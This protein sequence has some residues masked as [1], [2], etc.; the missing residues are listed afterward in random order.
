MKTR[1]YS[2][3]SDLDIPNAELVKKCRNL[4]F[5]VRNHMSTLDEGEVQVLKREIERERQEPVK[6]TVLKSGVLLRKGVHKPK[7]KPVEPEPPPSPP[8]AEPARAAAPE[9]APP[10]PASPAAPPG[11]A[12]APSPEAQEPAPAASEAAPPAPAPPAAPPGEAA[13]PSPEAQEPAPA[14][15][16]PAV[17]PAT[18][19]PEAEPPAEPA[20]AVK[21]LST[22]LEPVIE[23]T[24]RGEEPGM[25]RIV[26]QIELPKSPGAGPSR[27]GGR[28]VEQAAAQP[29]RPGAA[30]KGEVRRPGRRIE[31]MRATA[32]PT[33]DSRSRR[34]RK[35]KVAPGTKTRKTEITT[36]KASKRV[37]R[38]EGQ[39]S[40]QELAK[41]MEVKATEV[42]MKLIQLGMG[43]VNINSTLDVDT[44]KIVGSE[45]DYDVQD[46][47]FEEEGVLQEAVESVEEPG[48]EAREARAPVV[49]VMGHV[50][51]GKTSLLDSLRKTRVASGEA[52][53]ITQSIGASE[54]HTDTGKIVFVDT[55]GHEAFTEMRARGANVTDA[56]VLVV[57]AND[58]VQAQTIE[59]IDHARAAEVPIVVAINKMDLP[60]ANPDRVRKELADHGILSEQ[61][62]GDNLF[63]EVSAET[64]EGLDDLLDNILLQAE[65]LD[66]KANPDRPVHG[67]VIEAR[68]DKGKGAVATVLVQDG[69]LHTGDTVVAGAAYGRVRAMTDHRGKQVSEAGPSTA[70]E[71]QGLN[72][73]PQASDPVD[74]VQD[75]KKAQLVAD[76]R[77]SKMAQAEAADGTTPLTD[78]LSKIRAGEKAELK[79]ILKADVQGSL[80]AVR[81]AI[82][83]LGTEKVGTAVIHASVGGIT[84]SDV[85]LASASGALVVGFNV[86]PAGKA[87]SVA[88][89]ENVEIR[90]YTVIYD[91]LDDL[92]K[93]M[94][95]MLEPIVEEVEI[96][97]ARVKQTFNISKVGTVAGCEVTEGKVVRNAKVRLVRDSKVVWNGEIA[98]LKHF[99]DDVK[100]VVAGL[101]CGIGL[102]GFN[103]VK[104]GDVMEFIEQQE[105]EA[106]LE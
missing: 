22:P 34:P 72:Q 64:G 98:S 7:P 60:N 52:G 59:S 4:G 63:C 76:A 89:S 46:V 21:D 48:E 1:L 91:M 83:N 12:A 44:A 20:P 49:T 88:E 13:A 57:A 104:V 30:K 92:K 75:Q 94:V 18:A 82:L 62:G 95:G 87:R 27:A 81:N 25:P 56:V 90:M 16:E 41:A 71:I 15:A 29:G 85:N 58:G 5:S 96:G 6:E 42:L 54:I 99:K 35:K 38:I 102:A 66:L 67:T 24:P 103:D 97:A 39:I 3:A 101:E 45:F 28:P 53:G 9:A 11:E 93:T 55:P 73:V 86:R 26:G 84:E 100:E 36:P 31:E 79:V 105:R 65:V 14:A 43:G 2:I 68:L 10:A 70:V 61:W 78:I 17:E 37:V 106:S 74:G 47:S 77:A 8:S 80:E 33:W 40:L 32:V 19:P 69:T 50:D 23:P 51:H